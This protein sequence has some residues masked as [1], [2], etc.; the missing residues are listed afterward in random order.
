MLHGNVPK[1]KLIDMLKTL[2]DEMSEHGHDRPEDEEVDFPEDLAEA[3]AH[4]KL[5]KHKDASVR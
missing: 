4:K 5:L 3:L 2:G 1:A